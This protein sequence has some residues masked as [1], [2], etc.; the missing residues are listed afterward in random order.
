MLDGVEQGFKIRG[1]LFT[2]GYFHPPSTYSIQVLHTQS[3]GILASRVLD[4]HVYW[5]SPAVN[6]LNS[7]CR[8]TVTEQL[9][10]RI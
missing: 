8:C 5:V 4:L 6:S 2:F 1:F 3:S 10:S 9:T 7:S